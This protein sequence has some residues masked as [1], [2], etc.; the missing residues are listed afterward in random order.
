M[1][2]KKMAQLLI[3]YS[4]FH[5]L[6]QVIS[7]Q[8]KIQDTK[9]LTQICFLNN[10]GLIRNQ[11]L[12]TGLNLA[13]SSRRTTDMASKEMLEERQSIQWMKVRSNL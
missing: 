2:N 5:G 4:I 1:S 7:Y 10:E 3:E 13:T 6:T 12:M 8:V 11:T 9:E